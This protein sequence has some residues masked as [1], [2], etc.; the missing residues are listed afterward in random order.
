MTIK[1]AFEGADET[2]E[3]PPPAQ[4]YPYTDG[5]PPPELRFISTPQGTLVTDT[6]VYTYNPIAGNGITA[7]II[8]TGVS[9]TNSEFTD[10]PGGYRWCWPTQNFWKNHY[11]I[12]YN[13]DDDDDHGTCVLS[14]IVGRRFGVAKKTSAVILKPLPDAAGGESVSVIETMAR[15]REDIVTRGLQGK[16]VLNFSFNFPSVDEEFIAALKAIL[17]DMVRELDVVIVVASGND[18]VGNELKI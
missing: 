15:A 14:K 3:E 10:L 17:T 4:T 2:Y 7:Y 8:D 9:T 12:V 18:A 11:N 5:P 6:S 13:E 1:N 16:A